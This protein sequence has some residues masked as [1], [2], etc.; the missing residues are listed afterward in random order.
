MSTYRVE[1][2]HFV[3]GLETETHNGSEIVVRSAPILGWT[4]GKTMTEFLR[5]CLRKGW[6]VN[7]N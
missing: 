1:A 4:K 7:S 3:A 6:V 2:P 5:Y